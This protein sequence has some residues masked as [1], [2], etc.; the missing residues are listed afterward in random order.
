MRQLNETFPDDE[1]SKLKE[2]KGDRTWRSA[3]L[4]QFGVDDD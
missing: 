3:I 1:Y 2:V 4:E